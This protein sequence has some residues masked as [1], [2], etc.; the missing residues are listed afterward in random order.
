M[1][2]CLSGRIVC[3]RRPPELHDACQPRRVWMQM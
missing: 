1:A 3:L 2:A